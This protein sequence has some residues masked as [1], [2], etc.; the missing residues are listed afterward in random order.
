MQFQKNGITVS[1]DDDQIQRLV[2]DRLSVEPG[3]I[4]FGSIVAPRIGQ[5]WLGQGGIYAGAMR[6]RDGA[7]DYHLIVG[8]EFDGIS[9][10]G[11]LTKWAASLDIDSR[12]DFHL[13]YRK[14][15]ALCFANV[16]EL[17]KPEWYWSREQLE[18]ISSIAWSQDF[19]NG[20]QLNWGKAN[21]F[22]ARAV[23][24]LIIQ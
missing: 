15:Q 2:L 14:E 17:F 18:S 10:W 12:R 19:H 3:L 22:R 4:H 20:N 9:N 8:P 11:E 6:G 5:V 23:R 13:P 1:I 16:P 21:D 24:R 7:P